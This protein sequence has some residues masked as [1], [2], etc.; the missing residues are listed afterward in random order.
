MDWEHLGFSQRE[1]SSSSSLLLSRLH[2]AKERLGRK[3]EEKKRKKRTPRCIKQRVL[4]T[5]NR[6]IKLPSLCF[7]SNYVF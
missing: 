7:T 2:E 5:E 6:E 4:L 1:L 3:E